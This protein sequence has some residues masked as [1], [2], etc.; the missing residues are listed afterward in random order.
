[1]SIE[2][3]FAKHTLEKAFPDVCYAFRV[4]IAASRRV[5]AL[6]REGGPTVTSLDGAV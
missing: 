6:E 2:A 1:M 5:N 3:H 4:S